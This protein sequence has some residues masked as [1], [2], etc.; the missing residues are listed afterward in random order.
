[1]EHQGRGSFGF[2]RLLVLQWNSRPLF[3]INVL[4][5]S[6]VTQTILNLQEWHKNTHN[7]KS[8]FTMTRLLWGK[9]KPYLKWPHLVSGRFK[10]VFYKRTT[11][12]T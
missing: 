2:L 9:V 8:L 3:L 12:P 5:K 11:C 7:R 6:K 4:S 1:M 10:K